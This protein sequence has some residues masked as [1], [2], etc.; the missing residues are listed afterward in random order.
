MCTHTA[1]VFTKKDVE[2]VGPV[3]KTKMKEP[4]I[5]AVIGPEPV[6]IVSL[7][8]EVHAERGIKHDAKE[9]AKGISRDKT[10]DMAKG[11]SIAKKDMTKE[12]G[13]VNAK[14][15]A[16]Y[17]AKD[18]SSDV[19]KYM[20]KDKSSDVAK[21]MAKDK[22]SDVAKHMAKDVVKDVAKD[23]AK[24][25]ATENAIKDAMKHAKKD[26]RKGA[27][28]HTKKDEW[29]DAK[30]D[31]NEL[32][33]LTSTRKY[34]KGVVDEVVTK[35]MEKAS[36]KKDS[37]ERARAKMASQVSQVTQKQRV[38]VGLEDC[39]DDWK[40]LRSVTKPE[41]ITV[42]CSSDHY[43][44]AC[45]PS[46]ARRWSKTALANTLSDCVRSIFLSP[47][48][49]VKS[50]KKQVSECRKA[51]EYA[52]TLQCMKQSRAERVTQRAIVSG[53]RNRFEQDE[54]IFIATVVFRHRLKL[55]QPVFFFYGMKFCEWHV[56][57]CRSMKEMPDTFSMQAEL[58]SK[59]KDFNQFL[60]STF[61]GTTVGT[62]TIHDF[63]LNKTWKHVL[64][65]RKK[66]HVVSGC[67]ACRSGGE[68]LLL[69]KLI[70]HYTEH[71]RCKMNMDP[72]GYV[73]ISRAQTPLMHQCIRY[74]E[75]VFATLV[76]TGLI[77]ALGLIGCI[78]PCHI[79]P[80]HIR[81]CHIRPSVIMRIF[82]FI[83]IFV[84]VFFV[85]V[86]VLVL[87][88]FFV[89]VSVSVFVVVFFFVSVPV[90][91]FV[92][93][94]AFISIFVLVF[95]VSFFVFVLVF[96]GNTTTVFIR[97][98]VAAAKH[99]CCTSKIRSFVWGIYLCIGTNYQFVY[100]NRHL[101]MVCFS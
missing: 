44:L 92:S 56:Y 88:F 18:K 25:K 89:S 61:E 26:K 3:A 5:R 95:F 59:S 85:S 80:C 7:C 16:K 55:D 24:E 50:K 22:S 19:A 17:M 90:F 23:V 10:K 67:T 73:Q 40:W 20:A 81:P 57:R 34:T 68:Q 48:K 78:R 1:E 70:D 60:P 53:D 29:K 43:K 64:W 14:H 96:F 82:V 35:A 38:R 45:N 41:M 15:M 86:S 100:V 65:I 62:G 98:I 49:H 77:P 8:E 2:H 39:T 11:M 13:K 58:V 21:H 63:S 101:K 66:T 94:P 83:S 69:D 4:S 37:L 87:V 46:T 47:W 36:K 79:H 12:W 51:F 27:T 54:G 99:E 72:P 42:I 30:T 9:N 31:S 33:E 32:L 28:I 75:C 97:I 93:V 76:H 6:D 71:D 84:L 91:F 74:R 52:S